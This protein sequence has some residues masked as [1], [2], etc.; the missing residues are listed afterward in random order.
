MLWLNF[1]VVAALIS[2][3]SCIGMR[4]RQPTSKEYIVIGA[5]VIAYVVTAV[6]SVW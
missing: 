4:S 2:I 3:A 6:L 1:I 5:L